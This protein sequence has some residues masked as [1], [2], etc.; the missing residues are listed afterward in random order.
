[1][2][3]AGVA[4]AEG[5]EGLHGDAADGPAAGRLTLEAH[6]TTVTIDVGDGHWVDTRLTVGDVELVVAASGG[7]TAEGTFEA[8]L[9]LVETPH[10][11][12]V[13]TRHDGTA[14][15]GW[16]QVPLHGSDPLALVLP[17]DRAYLSP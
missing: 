1:M 3:L 14:W 6:G 12:L 9:R 8:D 5:D 7:W 4:E 13:R 11:V 16:H 17:G 2:R 15:L 10:R